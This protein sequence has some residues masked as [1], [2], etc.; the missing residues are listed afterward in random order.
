MV[1]LQISNHFHFHHVRLKKYC[2]GYRYILTFFFLVFSK[3][4]S[5]QGECTL[6]KKI[7]VKIFCKILTMSVIYIDV[8]K[9]L[10]YIILNIDIPLKFCYHCRHL[11]YIIPLCFKSCNTLI[12]GAICITCS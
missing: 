9:I 12:I 5:P 11:I 10:K 3:V 4:Y 6:K 1:F 2:P 7:L 8:E